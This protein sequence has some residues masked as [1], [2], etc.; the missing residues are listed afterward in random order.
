MY[1]FAFLFGRVIKLR[2]RGDLFVG[3]GR[4]VAKVGKWCSCERDV[5]ASWLPDLQPRGDA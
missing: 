4:G 2:H 3:G 5:D 1:T